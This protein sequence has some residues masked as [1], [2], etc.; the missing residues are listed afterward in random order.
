MDIRK[1]DAKGRL[2]G[3]N[4]GEHYQVE[5]RGAVFKAYRLV[6]LDEVLDLSNTPEAAPEAAQEYLRRFGIDPKDVLRENCMEEG[7]TSRVRDENGDWIFD[8]GA[9]RTVRKPWPKGFDWNE[10]VGLVTGVS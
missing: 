9:F 4:P 1:A 2:T 7:Y 6:Y 3:F 8:Y 10:F 5:S